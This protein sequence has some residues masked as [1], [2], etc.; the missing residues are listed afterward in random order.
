[1]VPI[2]LFASLILQVAGGSGPPP[3]HPFSQLVPGLLG[4]PTAAPSLQSVD[5]LLL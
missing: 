2:W 3:E 1:M 4:I 5:R